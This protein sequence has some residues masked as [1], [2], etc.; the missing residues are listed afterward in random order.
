MSKI[1]VDEYFARFPDEVQE[2][3]GELRSFIKGIV[4]DAEEKVGGWG[5]PAFVF[6][7]HYIVQYAAYAKHIGLYPEPSGME[8]FA[9]EAVMVQGVK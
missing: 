8:H 6:G 5:I 4:P 9:D 1:T 7:K 2:I 3:L